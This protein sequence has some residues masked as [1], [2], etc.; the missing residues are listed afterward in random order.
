M[1]KSYVYFLAPLVGVAVFSAVYWQYASG[2]EEKLAAAE[3]A[4]QEAKAEKIRQENVAKKA[5]VDGSAFITPHS[6]ASSTAFRCGH[7]SRSSWAASDS[8]TT[9]RLSPME[10]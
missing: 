5:A 2:Y 8:R 4:R 10:R 7:G 3:K 1:K 9:L 6:S